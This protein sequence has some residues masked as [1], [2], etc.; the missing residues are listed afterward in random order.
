LIESDS[1]DIHNVIFFSNKYCYFKLSINQKKSIIRR[2]VSL[3]VN[4]HFRMISEGLCDTEGWSNDAE[5]SAL[6]SQ[7]YV[8]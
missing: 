4:Q 8:L 3:A 7:E 6:P 2:K 1:K 5:N